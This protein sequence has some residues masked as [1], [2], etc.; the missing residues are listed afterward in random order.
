MLGSSDG[1]AAPDRNSIGE[2]PDGLQSRDLIGYSLL[3]GRSRDRSPKK[4]RGLSEIQLE[5]SSY[6]SLNNTYQ[7][8]PEQFP[9]LVIQC[10]PV[11]IAAQITNI[12]IPL[13]NMQIYAHAHMQFQ[14]RY[15]GS[16]ARLLWQSVSEV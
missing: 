11:T 13:L 16:H 5:L 4:R 8:A 12:H 10:R 6:A 7:Q 9:S 1:E 3:K 15:A 14:I 2:S